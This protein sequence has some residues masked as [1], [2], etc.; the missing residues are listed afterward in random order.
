ALE[1]LESPFLLIPLSGFSEFCGIVLR[2]FTQYWG[3]G[4]FVDAFAQQFFYPRKILLV[5]F[6]DEG[7][8]HSGRL[9][10]G[11]ASHTVH[12]IL[13]IIGYIKINNQVNGLYIYTTANNVCADKNS[14]T[15]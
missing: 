15:L 3:Q 2:S 13:R 14:Q 9:G 6:I 11:R 4:N 5:L 8:G 12:I 7:Q 10:P 1:F